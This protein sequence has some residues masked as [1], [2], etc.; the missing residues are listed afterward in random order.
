MVSI[1]GGDIWQLWPSVPIK[2]LTIN[3]LEMASLLN[4][5]ADQLPAGFE[6]V[7][8]GL[9][10]DA[11]FL[12][13]LQRWLVT[14]KGHTTKLKDTT[15]RLSGYLHHSNHTTLR[16]AIRRLINQAEFAQ[17]YLRT[18]GSNEV[19][20]VSTPMPMGDSLSFLSLRDHASPF[21]KQN[22]RNGLQKGYKYACVSRFSIPARFRLFFLTSKFIKFII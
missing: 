8:I 3:L 4:Q 21:N 7:S 12:E 5:T 16:P 15:E 20:L 19:V 13:S 6:E 18:N 1:W 14:I 22:N 17:R 11:L 2:V 10:N 9:K